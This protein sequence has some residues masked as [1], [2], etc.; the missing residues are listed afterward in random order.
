MARRDLLKYSSLA[1]GAVALGASTTGCSLLGATFNPAINGWL[2]QIG[3]SI[4]ANLSADGLVNGFQG[5]WKKWGDGVKKLIEDAP[6]EYRY[7][8][9]WCHDG[10]PVI[11]GGTSDDLDHGD[12]M[13]DSLVACVE[14]G[15]KAVVLEAWAW[16]AVAMYINDL[17]ADKE[18]DDLAQARRFCALSLI[19]C[20]T[21]PQSG[22][23]PAGTFGYISYPA[24]NGQVE[25]AWAKNTDGT[26]YA[27]ITATGIPDKDGQAVAKRFDLPTAAA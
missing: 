13:N 23:A 4:G 18:D 27:H 10:P 22:E 19:P 17:T 1:V 9:T 3:I 24:I 20:G 11:L 2:S 25:I 7:R 21:D 5:A 26:R 12:P 16:Q 14:D 15:T 6:K 8:E